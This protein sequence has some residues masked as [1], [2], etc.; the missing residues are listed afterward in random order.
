M[1]LKSPKRFL[2]IRWA[3]GSKTEKTK[4]KELSVALCT[5]FHRLKRA[6]CG[7]FSRGKHIKKYES[8]SGVQGAVMGREECMVGLEIK[9][10]GDWGQTEDFLYQAVEVYRLYSR[11]EWDAIKGFWAG[12]GHMVAAQ[13]TVWE[14]E[15]LGADRGAP[16]L[17][18]ARRAWSQST[19]WQSDTH[20]WAAGLLRLPLANRQDQDAPKVQGCSPLYMPL[21]FVLPAFQILSSLSHEVYPSSQSWWKSNNS[22]IHHQKLGCQWRESSFTLAKRLLKKI[23]GPSV[24]GAHTIIKHVTMSTVRHMK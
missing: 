7:V 14:K 10:K 1:C 15:N 17:H 6:G 16:G 11:K 5:G 8:A 13:G 19:G 18:T 12:K 2:L 24:A 20:L 4:A 9:G 21:S 3:R 22:N 23:H